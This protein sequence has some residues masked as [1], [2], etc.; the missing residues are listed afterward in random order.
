VGNLSFAVFKKISNSVAITRKSRM[1]FRWRPISSSS[2]QVHVIWMSTFVSLSMFSIIAAISNIEIL[3]NSRNQLASCSALLL[4]TWMVFDFFSPA[5]PVPKKYLI[6]HH[7]VAFFAILFCLHNNFFIPCAWGIFL[8]EGYTLLFKKIIDAP[9]LDLQADLLR[10]V[11][12]GALTAFYFPEINSFI[13]TLWLFFIANNMYFFRN[14]HIKALQGSFQE[15][16][17]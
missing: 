3:I 2:D 9:I 8:Q 6:F 1:H 11:I 5:L 15:E 13:I 14:T 4:I 10:F 7:A 17:Q 16:E 12:S